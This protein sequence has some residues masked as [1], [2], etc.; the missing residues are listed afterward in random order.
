MNYCRR[1]SERIGVEKI[2][3]E[4]HVERLKNV[5]PVTDCH[6][7]GP[8][9]RPIPRYADENSRFRKRVEKENVHLLTRLSRVKSGTATHHHMSIVRQLRWKQY[10]L[11]VERVERLKRI[12][13]QNQRL[14]R[15]IQTV[16]PVIK[17][18][19]I[20]SSTI[21]KDTKRKVRFK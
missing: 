12:T 13:Q 6:F 7:Y 19:P 14:L 11:H 2:M 1:R 16:K 18:P 20:Y 4:Q 9:I 21:P 5:R 10:L 15:N 17:L 8:K 3:Y